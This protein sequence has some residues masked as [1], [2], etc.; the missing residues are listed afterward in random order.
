MLCYISFEVPLLGHCDVL[1][2]KELYL[3]LSD[4]V[5]A[6]ALLSKPLYH[7]VIFRVLSDNIESRV[8]IHFSSEVCFLY[9]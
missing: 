6:S 8:E 4:R 1:F 9:G 5:P 3:N 7:H 2:P